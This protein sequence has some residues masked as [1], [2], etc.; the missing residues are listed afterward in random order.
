MKPDIRAYN[1]DAWNREVDS[2]ENEWTRPVS[3][4]VIAAARRGDWQIILTP[5]I[6]VPSDWSP[7]LSGLDVLCLAGGGGQQG[8]VLAAAGAR[9]T[10]FDNSPRQLDQDRQVAEREGL[11]MR[12]L[13]GDMRDLSTFPDESFGLIVHPVSNLFVDDILS[14]WREAYR[15]LKSGGVLISGFAN[16]INY[17]F[18][19]QKMDEQGLL[20]VRFPLPYS[21]VDNPDLEAR[22]AFFA[23]GQPLEW[24]HT[25]EEQ[26]GGQLQAGFVIT[27]F[28]ED[29]YPRMM[30]SKYMP[31]F[32]NTRA[33][34]M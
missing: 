32:F 25:F 22:E 23:T 18:D 11:D 6:P 17:I 27:G 9:V 5:L 14:V 24:S 34:K 28:F 16:P 31:T 8:P 33:V 29:R 20:E 2:G 19:F 12:I 26:I 3:P 30:F 7:P 10:V 21:D 15:V 1:R 13:E 4:E